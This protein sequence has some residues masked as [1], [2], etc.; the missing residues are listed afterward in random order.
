MS[1]GGGTS[2]CC[3]H[4]RDLENHFRLNALGDDWKDLLTSAEET[5]WLTYRTANNDLQHILGSVATE[6]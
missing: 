6:F 1:V 3:L 2:V 4:V 5:N